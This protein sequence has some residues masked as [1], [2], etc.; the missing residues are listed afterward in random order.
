MISFLDPSFRCTG[1][2][3]MHSF[4]PY[5]E[6]VWARLAQ[7]GRNYFEW[8]AGRSTVAAVRS[9]IPTISV[10]DSAFWLAQA[11][12]Q[13]QR[14]PL[15][16]ALRRP[17]TTDYEDALHAYGGNV[18]AIL[19]DG[20]RR[21]ECAFAARRW[22]ESHS[23]AIILLHDAARPAY[24]SALDAFRSIRWVAEGTARLYFPGR[25]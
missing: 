23:D 11:E 6:G 16:S 2:A 19:I 8:G 20:I 25:A 12:R 7:T 4:L 13:T 5:L 10:D 24:R 3:P 21:V 9:G 14:S 15:L 22:A 18:G 1:D 17:N